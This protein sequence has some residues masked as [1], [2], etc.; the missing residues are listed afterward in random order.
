MTENGFISGVSV[1]CDFFGG[2]MGICD[3]SERE[4]G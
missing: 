4:K 1:S 3:V 2:E